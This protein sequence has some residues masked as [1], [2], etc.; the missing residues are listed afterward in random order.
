MKTPQF[1]R[2]DSITL[3]LML[4]ALVIIT[5]M[6]FQDT[7]EPRYAEIARLMYNSGDWI[8]PWFEPGKPFWGK[9]PLSFWAAAASMHIFGVNEFAARF[10]SWLSMVL[11]LCATRYVFVRVYGIETAQWSVLIYASMILVFVNIG[12]VL[13]DPF[14]ALGTTLVFCSFIVCMRQEPDLTHK[15]VSALPQSPSSRLWAYL[16]FIG[17]AIGLLAKGPLTVVLVGAPIAVY[18]AWH[19][20]R[21]SCFMRAYPWLQGLLLVAVLVLPWYILAEIKTPGFLHY[22][23]VGE[24]FLRFVDPG[25]QGDLY[26]TAHQQAYGTIWLNALVASLPWWPVV[27]LVLVWRWRQGDWASVRDAFRAFPLFSFVFSWALFCGVFFTFSGNILWTYLLPSMVAVALIFAR[28]LP[29]MPSFKWQENVPYLALLVPSLFVVIVALGA[30][31][32]NIWRTEKHLVTFAQNQGQGEL[33]YY[34]EQPFS[35]RF[36]SEEE[37]KT[38]DD[39]GLSSLHQRSDTNWYIA[40]SKKAIEEFNQYKPEGLSLVFENKRYYLFKHSPTI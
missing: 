40:V 6:P 15:S 22:F 24:H 12:A 32:P 14:L 23:I 8:T 9:P 38:V 39:F 5:F 17:L 35:A 3:V 28:V 18:L 19:K 33:Y 4:L 13:T 27:V 2:K 36:Y 1:S 30:V 21:W 11:S 34:K 10:P 7:S 37:A 26:G 16:G 25:W 20:D 29:L 31:Y